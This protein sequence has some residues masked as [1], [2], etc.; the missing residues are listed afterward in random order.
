MRATS[1]RSD[2]CWGVRVIPLRMGSLSPNCLNA[3]TIWSST[4]FFSSMNSFRSC[5]VSEGLLAPWRVQ[6][7]QLFSRSSNTMKISK[8][9]T[10]LN[11]RSALLDLLMQCF[12]VNESHMS[13][14]NCSWQ[15][16]V[17]SLAN[18]NN[19]FFSWMTR[20]RRALFIRTLQSPFLEESCSCLIR[21][22]SVGV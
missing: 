1:K 4:F 6:R 7:Y 15:S 19:S 14:S 13:L 2:N 10:I 22:W 5:C 18:S 16:V 12:D 21:S 20:T 9:L 17:L 3:S 8:R 11:K